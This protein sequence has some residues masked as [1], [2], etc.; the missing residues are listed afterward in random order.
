VLD[1]DRYWVFDGLLD[2]LEENEN[3]WHEEQRRIADD[4]PSLFPGVKL[5]IPNPDWKPGRY[6]ADSDK[7]LDIVSKVW[8][9]LFNERLREA[10]VEAKARSTGHWSPKEYNFHHDEAEFALTI[11]KR[12]AKR[13]FG[14]CRADEG[15]AEHLRRL[16]SSRDGFISFVTNDA[17]VF[18]DNA[19]G[20]HGRHEH[21]NA[22]WQALN[23][24]MF[25]DREASEE[26]NRAFQERVCDEDFSGI[27]RFVEES[28]EELA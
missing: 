4:H 6:E 8:V 28:G 3:Y 18:A 7:F 17:D 2:L 12:E 15:F 20:K 21:E 16:Y 9:E 24:V 19:M 10:G 27:M 5:T 25:P 23:F 1:P 22:V 11:L 14:L 26:W 13:L